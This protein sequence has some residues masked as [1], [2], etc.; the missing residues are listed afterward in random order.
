MKIEVGQYYKRTDRDT[1]IK[2]IKILDDS[3]DKL[4][5]KLIK[6]SI[7]GFEVPVDRLVQLNLPEINN[8][9]TRYY[10]TPEDK[11]RMIK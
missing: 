6:S 9:Y 3:E 8:C 10:L 7:T 11:L 5:V 1:I 2:I 4:E